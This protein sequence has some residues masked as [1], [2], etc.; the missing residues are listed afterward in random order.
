MYR[1][2]GRMVSVLASG[3]V[4]GGFEP[5]SGQTNDYKIC[6]CCFSV[7]PAALRRKSK[8]W[9]ARNQNKVSQ[10]DDMSIHG[11][12]FQWAST[13]KIQLSVLVWYKTDLIIISLKIN[14]FLAWYSWKI[15]LSSRWTTITHSLICM[16]N[17]PKMSHLRETTRRLELYKSKTVNV[18]LIYIY[19][20]SV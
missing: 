20:Y 17:V 10:F 7:K 13:I 15:L 19:I 12:L 18:T 11:L 3:A 16:N 4:D 14:L 8:D 2:G 6:I 5:R 9:L 1:I